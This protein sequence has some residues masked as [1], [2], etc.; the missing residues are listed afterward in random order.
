LVTAAQGAEEFYNLINEARYE[1]P[2]EAVRKDLLCRKAYVNHPKH[3]IIYNMVSKGFDEKISTCVDA[4]YSILGLESFTIF[5]KKYLLKKC[6][7]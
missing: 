5:F 7:A 1:D 3:F 4:V 2:K 6:E